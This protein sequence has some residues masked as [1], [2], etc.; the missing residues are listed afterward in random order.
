MPLLFSTIHHETYKEMIM[1][2]ELIEKS[3]RNEVISRS[4]LSS[5]ERYM[6][7]KLPN[8]NKRLLL[9]RNKDSQTR[10]RKKKGRRKSDMQYIYSKPKQI[11]SFK[12]TFLSSFAP[13]YLGVVIYQVLWV[14]WQ[15]LWIY[16]RQAKVARITFIMLLILR[17][18]YVEM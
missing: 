2:R 9:S 7:S 6:L 13:F 3:K 18:I 1:M 10:A 12:W 11:N 8:H 16:P 17:I 4:G 14:G 15:L 5:K